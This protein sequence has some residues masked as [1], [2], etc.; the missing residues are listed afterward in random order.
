M[1]VDWNLELRID[2]SRAY[3]NVAVKRHRASI[4][5]AKATVI[6]GRGK[7]SRAFAAAAVA[8]KPA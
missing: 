7:K 8:S 3:G 4:A 2:C 5:Q 1:V 6:Q